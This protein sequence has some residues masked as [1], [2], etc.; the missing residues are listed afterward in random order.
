M[1]NAINIHKIIGFTA[2]TAMSVSLLM[3]AGC[4][5]KGGYEAVRYTNRINCAKLPQ[6]QY[7]ECLQNNNMDYEEYERERKKVIKGSDQ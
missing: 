5:A 1:R 3:N 6:P 4:S 2:V 7:E